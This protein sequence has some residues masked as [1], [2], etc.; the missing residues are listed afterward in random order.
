[1]EHLQPYKGCWIGFSEVSSPLAPLTQMMWLFSAIPGSTISSPITDPAVHLK[2]I[3]GHQCLKMWVGQGG[4]SLPQL[5]A[6]RGTHSPAHGTILGHPHTPLFF[7]Y[8]LKSWLNLKMITNWPGYFKI[9]LNCFPC[10]SPQWLCPGSER[11]G[12][13]QVWSQAAIY[14][15]CLRVGT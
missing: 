12:R 11:W 3:F 6:G 13:T 8:L 14:S 4:S 7:P 1:M 10:F 9:F 5:S 2:S 15:A